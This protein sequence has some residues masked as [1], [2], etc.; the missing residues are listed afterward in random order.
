MCIYQR[1][2]LYLINKCLVFSSEDSVEVD[3]K[4]ERKE[5]REGGIEGWSGTTFCFRGILSKA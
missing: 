4:G 5:G 3:E 2:K 1:T